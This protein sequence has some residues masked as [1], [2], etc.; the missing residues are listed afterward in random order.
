MFT[1]RTRDANML[2][3][4]LGEPVELALLLT[5]ALHDAHAGDVFLHDVGDVAGLLLRV[6]AR[7]EHRRAQL[8]RG[9]QQQGRDRE[10]HERQERRQPEHGA[11]DTMNSRMF[12]TPIGR[13]CKKPWRS[14]T[15]DDARLTS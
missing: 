11:N 1:R 5:E 9:E 12:A 15:S 7:R 6:P 3:G 10:H 8:H 13:N 2:R 14:A 4:T